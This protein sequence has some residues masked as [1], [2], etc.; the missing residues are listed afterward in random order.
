M[1][2][3]ND[4]RVTRVALALAQA[5]GVDGASIDSTYPPSIWRMW[6][7]FRHS[8]REYVVAF[9]VLTAEKNGEA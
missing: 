1:I 6:N 2:D 7:S 5:E 8:A 9:D 3:L 4:P